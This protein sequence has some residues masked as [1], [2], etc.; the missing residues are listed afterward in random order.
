MNLLAC[1]KEPVA[2]LPSFWTFSWMRLPRLRSSL[3]YESERSRPI[4]LIL[5]SFS[6]RDFIVCSVPVEVDPACL[7]VK[8]E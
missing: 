4:P 5:E 2:L 6:L 8:L 1:V 7:A 3:S